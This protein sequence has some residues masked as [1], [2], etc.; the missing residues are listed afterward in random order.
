[1]ATEHDWSRLVREPT[2]CI[3]ALGRSLA[4]ERLPASDRAQMLAN[5][6][7]CYL[8]L[9]LTK[10]C[11]KVTLRKLDPVLKALG[12]DYLKPL[13]FQVVGFKY[14]LAPLRQGLRRRDSVRRRR[15]RGRV[16]QAVGWLKAPGFINAWGLTPL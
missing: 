2:T 9:E 16:V 1:M 5:R 10:S 8:T 13:P 14:D 11:V 15:A 7:R 6:A 12:F 4:E 3:K